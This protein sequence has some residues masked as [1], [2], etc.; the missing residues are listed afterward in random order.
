MLH[1]VEDHLLRAADRERMGHVTDT[2]A[3]TPG[4]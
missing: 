2:N 4:G 3:I 1:E